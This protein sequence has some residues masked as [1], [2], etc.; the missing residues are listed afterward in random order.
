MRKLLGVVCVAGLLAGGPVRAQ[1]A[2]VKAVLDKAIAAHG[3]ADHLAKNKA[4]S[5]HTKGKLHGVVG[6]SVDVTGD[7]ASQLPDRFR[8]EMSVTVMGM[9][10]KI[11]Q[12]VNGDKGWI[13]LNDKVMEL[14]KEQLAEGKE[15]MHV[16]AVARLVGLRD[17]AYKLSALGDAKVEGK[18]AVGIRVEHKDHRDVSLYFDKKTG[19]L[20]KTET[21]AKDPMAGD[22]EFTSETIYGDYKKVDDAPV[23]HK[24]TVKRDGKLFLE[25]ENSDVKVS[26][27]L[28][29]STFE[30]PAG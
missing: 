27:K 16:G 14:T 29:D 3:G 1:E 24:I 18:D 22:K 28:D 7:I 2:D 30:K 5:M 10:F 4:V 6:D 21:R 25:S 13:V 8:F 26:E 17:K 23:A 11:T 15:Q 9:D 19:L 12:V 20:L